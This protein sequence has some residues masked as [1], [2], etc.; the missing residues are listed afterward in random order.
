MNSV[1]PECYR[2][3]FRPKSYTFDDVML[4]VDLALSRG[5]FVSINYLNCPGFTDAAE[6]AGRAP[7]HPVGEGH[8]RRERE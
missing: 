3:Y 8:Q 4:S 2:A 6:E 5:R 1:R 7:E